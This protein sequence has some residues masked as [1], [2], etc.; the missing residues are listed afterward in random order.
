VN[1]VNPKSLPQV[2]SAAY[3]AEE[4]EQSRSKYHQEMKE[5]ATN[6]KKTV[7]SSYGP[8]RKPDFKRT[9]FYGNKKNG[10]FMEIITGEGQGL[11]LNN[12]KIIS[13][14]VAIDTHLLQEPTRF[15]W[16]TMNLNKVVGPV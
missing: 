11:P 10:S 15:Q 4:K 3:K 1:M 12:K 13:R 8:Y 6:S 2:V 5:K 14:L 9:D 16:Q 7:I